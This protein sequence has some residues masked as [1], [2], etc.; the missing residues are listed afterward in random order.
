MVAA[1]L[2]DVTAARSTGLAG[3]H[4]FW[5]DWCECVISR[6]EGRFEWCDGLLSYAGRVDSLPYRSLEPGFGRGHGM[7]YQ[8][9]NEGQANSW[10]VWQ[11][12]SA[13]PVSRIRGR[14]VLAV[15]SA[16]RWARRRP[17]APMLFCHVYGRTREGDQQIPGRSCSYLVALESGTS[18]WCRI[19]DVER[20]RADR[21]ETTVAIA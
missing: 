18:S 8:A 19:L 9:L 3:S 14:I 6:V 15:D 4:R 2:H 16:A 7:V 20:I 1:A 21:T 13:G 5:S 11:L 10:Q 12:L 17:W